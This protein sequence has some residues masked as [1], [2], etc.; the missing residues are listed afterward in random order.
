MRPMAIIGPTGTGKSEFALHIAERLGGKCAVEVVNA[1]APRLYRGMDIGTGKLPYAQRRN[2]PHHQMDV[3]DITEAASVERYQQAAKADVEA[4]L[5]RGALPILVGGSML[6][7]QALLDDWKFPDTDQAVRTRWEQ[8]L[9]E[10][11]PAEL[12]LELERRDPAAAAAIP[13]ADT[14]RTVRALEVIEL[15]GKPFSAHAPRIGKPRW[16]TVIIG[17]DCDTRN[18]DERLALRTK[19][20]FDQGLVEEVVSLLRRGLGKS[21]T[22]SRALGYAQ[23]IATLRE[24]GDASALQEAQRRTSLATR[25]HVRR[26]RSWFRRDPR[27]HWL[28]ISDGT[29]SGR[30]DTIDAALRTWQA[31]RPARFN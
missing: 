2:I 17:L 12:H 24:G 5:A 1:E 28:D 21:V 14:R 27:V 30:Q 23:I 9:S 25:R 7:V 18:L 15:T 31:G 22:A 16:D 13:I 26:Q 6:Y 29:L 4:I 3:L 20:M 8:R 10:V 19:Q 11:G